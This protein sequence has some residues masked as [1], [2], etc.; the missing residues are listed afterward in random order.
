MKNFKNVLKTMPTCIL[1]LYRVTSLKKSKTCFF[2]CKTCR[3]HNPTISD[4]L[5]SHNEDQIFDLLE[6]VD[7]GKV[8]KCII[9]VKKE[10][11][12]NMTQYNLLLRLLL[13]KDFTQTLIDNIYDVFLVSMM[14]SYSAQIQWRKMHNG[15]TV[16]EFFLLNV[17]DPYVVDMLR[18][19]ISN[20][21]NNHNVLSLLPA[22]AAAKRLAPSALSVIPLASPP[23]AVTP[24]MPPPYSSLNFQETVF[25]SAPREPFF[26]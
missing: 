11:F 5:S 6:K 26:W 19:K 12:K 10:K 2:L 7:I 21:P 23:K 24:L 13:K 20:I 15:Y 22:S 16:L 3:K 17:T 14:L 8:F 9:R 4:L 18:K 25:P 1:C